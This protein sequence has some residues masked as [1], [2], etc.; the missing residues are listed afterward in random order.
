MKKIIFLILAFGFFGSI[1]LSAQETSD[2]IV[3][4]VVKNRL[5]AMWPQIQAVPVTWS[6]DGGNYKA[7][8][9]ILEKPAFAIID[10]AGK[11]IKVE[12]RLGVYYLPKEI[13][14]SLNK[15]FPEN[16]VLDIYEFTNSNGI[17]T[18]NITYKVKTTSLFNSDG[19]LIQK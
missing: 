10:P 13:T 18:Y 5:M 9:L 12:R 14:A 15:Q 16:E 2:I 8:I 1:A 7:T 11:L 3:P 6:M 17:K 4:E 19:K